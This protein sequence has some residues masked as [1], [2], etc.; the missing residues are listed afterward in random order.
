MLEA[1]HYEFI[2][3]AILA[4]VLTGIVCGAL[5]SLVVVNR[6]VFIS[7]GI[8]H[9]AY[10][11]IGLAVYLGIPFLAGTMGFTVAVAVIM[12]LVVI[13]MKH[14]ADTI[15]GALWAVGMAIGIILTD[16]TPGYNVDLISYLFGSILTV[17]RSDLYQMSL[18]CSIILFLVIFFYNDFLALSYDSEFAQLR[19]VPVKILYVL[20]MILI[21]V[22]IVMVIRVVGMILVIAL[23]TIPPFIAEKY[24][25]SL[26]TMMLYSA[27]LAI[28]FSMA[29]I[30]LSYGFNLTSGA[31]IILVSG[32]AFFLSFLIGRKSSGRT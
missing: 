1:L 31:A 32:V 3:N 13:K 2:Q 28:A 14:R 9:A 12:A 10:G 7:G 27:L 29:G 18:L 26:G 11:G 19:G 20:L 15:I 5:G 25:D 16:L 30:A 22:S 8:A 17:S 4:G 21:A 23:L 24:A 6:I